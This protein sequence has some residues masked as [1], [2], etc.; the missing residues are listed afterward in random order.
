MAHISI[1]YGNIVGRITPSN[2]VK[3]YVDGSYTI[4]KEHKGAIFS[5]SSYSTNSDTSRNNT[6]LQS[7]SDNITIL[8][9]DTRSA[10]S[11][12]VTIK[13]F[14]ADL[15]SK[16]ATFTSKSVGDLQL[17]IAYVD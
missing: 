16:Q 15:T 3:D 12:Y 7:S 9:Y 13:Y 4:P 17:L 5:I 10:G 14:Y 6:L 1:D 2:L 11:G 8:G